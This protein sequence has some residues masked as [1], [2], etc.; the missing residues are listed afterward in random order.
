MSKAKANVWCRDCGEEMKQYPYDILAFAC[1]KCGLKA[2]VNYKPMPIIK[3][4]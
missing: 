2:E 4:I 1:R 3:G